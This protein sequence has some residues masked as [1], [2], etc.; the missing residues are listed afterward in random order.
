MSLLKKKK[1][2]AV[3]V[4]F[5]FLLLVFLFYTV[6]CGSSFIGM[7]NSILNSDSQN[8]ERN[9]SRALGCSRENK[10]VKFIVNYLSNKNYLV[11]FLNNAEIRP[12]GGFMGSYADIKFKDN[13]LSSWSISDIYIPDGQLEGHVDPPLPIQQAFRTGDW[14]LRNANWDVNFPDAAHDIVWFF[15]KGKVDNIDGIIAINLGLV[16]KWLEIIGPVKP[17]DFAETVNSQNFSSIAQSYAEDDFFPGSTKKGNYLSSVGKAIFD[18]T[19]HINSIQKLKLIHLIYTQ[20]QKQQILIWLK[21][22][23]QERLINSLAWDGSLGSYAY[24]YTYPIESNLGVNKANY[25]VDRSIVK[26]VDIDDG[27]TKSTLKIIWSNNYNSDNLK[28]KWS[29]DY[30]NYQRIVLPLNAQILK[31]TTDRA[32]LKLDN[33]KDFFNLPD[34]KDD[35]TYTEE[36][37]NNFKIIGFWISIPKQSSGSVTL[38]YSLPK[39]TTRGYSFVFKHQPGIYKIP[40]TIYLN[41]RQVFNKV[42]ES[43]LFFQK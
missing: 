2:I 41:N 22:D 36:I 43:D 40:M 24:D 37:K 15:E 42:V 23:D 11:L 29:G 17:Y 14:K 38:E 20:L 9:Y 10:S 34:P 32:G 25:F 39:P 33:N 26:N 35:L 1:L 6:S 13:V 30:L 19:L 8:F 7:G 27:Q 3:F 31:I 21:D 5:S 16:N 28:S 18:K 4:I 12:G